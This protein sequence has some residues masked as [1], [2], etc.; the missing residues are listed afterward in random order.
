MFPDTAFCVFASNRSVVIVKWLDLSQLINR[1]RGSRRV[2][3]ILIKV[4]MNASY[5]VKSCPCGSLRNHFRS[6]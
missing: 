5:S 3:Y 6:Q 1:G 2:T 4:H